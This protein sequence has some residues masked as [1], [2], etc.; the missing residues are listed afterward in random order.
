MELLNL[1]SCFVK[2]CYN[3]G[4]QKDS[5][6]QRII[7]SF[8]NLQNQEKVV[9]LVQ[10]FLD[11]ASYVKLASLLVNKPIWSFI[12]MAKLRC[13]CI[14]PVIMYLH[15]ILCVKNNLSTFLPLLLYSRLFGTRLLE[16]LI[17]PMQKCL[18]KVYLK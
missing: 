5:F 13:C 8:R 11:F 1:Y 2:L 3:S 15:E 4:C 12:I 14:H 6:R 7:M 10:L 18:K 17:L 9:P 16:S